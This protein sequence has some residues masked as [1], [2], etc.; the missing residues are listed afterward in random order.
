MVV[1]TYNPST[2]GA[3]AGLQIES[4]TEMHADCLKFKQN[5]NAQRWSTSELGDKQTVNSNMPA[6]QEVL[7]N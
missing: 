1:H 5:N 2:P 7:F 6:N 4:Q 3:G